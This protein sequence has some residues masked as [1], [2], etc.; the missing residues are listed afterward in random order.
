MS[1]SAIEAVAVI[2]GIAV[3]LYLVL[4]LYRSIVGMHEEDTLYLSAGES[5]LAEEQRVV[6][7]QIHRLDSYSRKIGWFAL[8][9]T[10]VLAGMWVYDVA[11][12]L[13]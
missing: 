12:N 5:R 10:V 7:K 4:F 13:F 6:M 8:A 3:A 1:L 2:W 9:M 11:K